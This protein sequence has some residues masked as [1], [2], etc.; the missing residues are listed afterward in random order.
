VIF[1]T[2]KNRDADIAKCLAMGAD[3]YITKPFSNTELVEEV[4]RLIGP[5]ER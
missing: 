1:L 2:S 4:R 3:A 5:G